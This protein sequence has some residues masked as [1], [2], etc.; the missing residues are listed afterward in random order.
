MK[1]KDFKQLV[2]ESLFWKLLEKFGVLGVQFILQIILARLLSPNDYGLIAITTIFITISNVF[3]QRGFCSALVQ[4][5]KTTVEDFNSVFTISVIIAVFLYS[6][7][8]FIAPFIAQFYG[9]T[10]L[11]LIL[12]IFAIILFFGCIQSLQNAYIAKKFIFKIL[13]KSSM[14]STVISGV[15]SITMAYKGYGVWSLVM[16]RLIN[17]VLI[18][19]IICINIRWIPKISFKFTNTKELFTYGWKL[20]IS[21]L[22]ENLYI[23]ISSLIIGKLYN[24]SILGYY[25]RGKQ[26][27]SIIV[28]SIDGSIQSVIF[29]TLSKLQNNENKLKNVV[30]KSIISSTFII[31]PLMIGLAIV[32]ESL[33]KVVLTEKWLLA[34]PFLRIFC[35]TYVLYPIHTINLQ[36]INALG[37]S[38]IYLKLEIIK[39][40]LG[41]LILLISINFGVYGIALGILLTSLISTFINIYPNKKL[42]NYGYIE[43]IKDLYVTIIMSILMGINMYILGLFFCNDIWKLCFQIVCGVTSYM[44]L[45]YF[46]NAKIFIYI[47]YSVED[48]LSTR[49]N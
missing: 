26:F 37:R 20:T 21:S 35:A 12:R 11:I 9:E 39:K 40:I 28:M 32:S 17:H 41:F 33:I 43:Q 38:D 14:I 30:K 44:L 31:F 16:Q 25:N 15:I 7:L 29:P 13:F 18:V 47:K 49:K 27:P 19:I 3:I 5:S 46:F 45:T 8:Y 36:V 24:T 22:I 23:N 42:L 10:K 34:V 6:M 4:R 48:F 2:M 1:N